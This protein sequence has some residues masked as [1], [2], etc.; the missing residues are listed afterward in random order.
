MNCPKCNFAIPE[1]DSFCPKC[2]CAV[3]SAAAPQPIVSTPVDGLNLRGCATVAPETPV[4]TAAVPQGP[5]KG[6]AVAAYVLYA[7]AFL[8]FVGLIVIGLLGRSSGSSIKLPDNSI[9]SAVKPNGVTV[10]PQGHA[11]YTEMNEDT[12][13]ALISIYE[14]Y[15]TYGVCPGNY[16]QLTEAETRSFLGEAG[17]NPDDYLNYT[18]Y[19]MTDCHSIDTIEGHMRIYVTE[20]FLKKIKVAKEFDQNQEFFRNE[21]NG[22]VYY[23]AINAGWGSYYPDLSTLQEKDGKWVVAMR[24]AEE[25]DFY[26]AGVM[27]FVKENGII[28][29]SDYDTKATLE[30]PSQKPT[31]TP[32]APTSVPYGHKVYTEMNSSSVQ[33]LIDNYW[34]YHYCG[35]CRGEVE[36]IDFEAAVSV[37]EAAGL[38]GNISQAYTLNRLKCCNTLREM[39][40]HA[41]LYMTA[42]VAKDAYTRTTTSS[43]F[44]AA[45]TFEAD[46]KAYVA[47]GNMGHDGIYVEDGTL[48]QENGKW[49]V[50]TCYYN[51]GEDVPVPAFKFTFNNDAGYYRIDSV[52]PL[53]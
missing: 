34:C 33:F 36:Y 12:A 46:G 14:K 16:T 26:P 25:G 42:E 45:F 24:Y 4:V 18:I 35:E 11:V 27:T 38:D 6:L 31:V 30:S 50:K 19:R 1:G 3:E 22:K 52:T 9:D 39:D 5:S 32:E 20:S 53:N 13:E 43:G 23:G 28:K 40:Q 7:I 15:D 51:P 44:E 49:T 29:I 37:F 47:W 17:G 48:K 8:I 21:L 41:Q 2:G 10:V